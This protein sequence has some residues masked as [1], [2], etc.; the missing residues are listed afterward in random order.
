MTQIHITPD[1]ETLKALLGDESA[2]LVINISN[3]VIY[4]YIEKHLHDYFNEEALQKAEAAISDLIEPAL[5]KHVADL[6]DYKIKTRA[7]EIEKILKIDVEG[8][9]RA[10]IESKISEVANNITS[11]FETGIA[12]K[13]EAAITTQTNVKINQEITDRLNSIKEEIETQQEQTK[14][15]K[16]MELSERA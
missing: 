10:A 15:K 4:S 13:I 3:D 12:Q 8:R 2:P 1:I 11:N 16:Q 5:D 14:S 7:K 6:R 9:V